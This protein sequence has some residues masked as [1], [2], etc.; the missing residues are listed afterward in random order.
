MTVQAE[1]P[2]Y[3]KTEHATYTTVVYA[4]AA[5]EEEVDISELT[6]IE[7]FAVKDTISV[8]S[9]FFDGNTE[10]PANSGDYPAAPSVDTGN[11]LLKFTLNDNP[12][13]ANT[14][15]FTVSSD[16]YE[17][18]LAV[19]VVFTT[20]RDKQIVTFDS[21]V[22]EDGKVE[23]GYGTHSFT[24]TASSNYAD[25]V[26]SYSSDNTAVASVDSAGNVA[27]HSAGE[28]KITAKAA[29]TGDD[30][31]GGY[32]A[33]SA[34]YVL[35]VHKKPVTVSGIKAEDKTYNGETG[36]VLD[37]SGALIDGVLEADRS[38]VSVEATGAFQD[39]NAGSGKTVNLSEMVLKGE[40]SGNYFIPEDGQQK[41][42]TAAISKAEYK[43]V[44]EVSRNTYMGASDSIDL[45]QMIAEG[46]T[47]VSSGI[48][49]ED[50]SVVLDGDPSVAD[51]KLNYKFADN[52][53]VGQQAIVTIPVTSTNYV[54]YNI[55]V[56]LFVTSL[57]R[58]TLTFA[59]VSEGTVETT[60]GESVTHTA[61]PGSGTPTI[62]YSS[63][64]TSIAT[65]DSSTGK[66]TTHKN[67]TVVISAFA[68][69]IPEH[70]SATESYS[71][72][73]KKKTAS[74]SWATDSLTY[75]GS[76][77]A[78]AASVSNKVGDDSITVT[79][80]GQETSVGEGYTATAV[81]LSDD[82]YELPELSDR[83][84]TF[85]I[86][87]KKVT[88][89]GTVTYAGKVYDGTVNAKAK[90]AE[91]SSWTFNNPPF[92]GVVEEDELTVA[93]AT[94]VFDNKN[95]GEN[96]TLI[97]TVTLG[98][99]SAANYQI[100]SFEIKSKIEKKTATV[101]GITA[102]N[103][104]YDGNT[105]AVMVVSGASLTG[106]LDDDNEKVNVSGATGSFADKNVAN[107]KA[108]TI[109][110]VTLGGDEA[111]NYSPDYSGI[112][113]LTANITEKKLSG[114]SWTMPDD[115]VYN[116]TDRGIPTAS[117]QGVLTGDEVELSV[118]IDGGPAVNRGSY[119]ARA[120][121]SAGTDKGNYSL[122][123]DPTTTMT[124]SPLTVTLEWRKNP[125][126][127]SPATGDIEYDYN[128]SPQAPTATVG[129]L[130]SGDG[131]N[132]TVSVEGE[133]TNVG[134][135]TA[136]AS[137]LGG[138][139][140]ANY[141]LPETLSD[142]QKAYSI[143]QSAPD[144]S[145]LPANQKP[146][147][148][149]PTYN[150]QPQAIIA[151]P[152]EL[153]SG[154]TNVQYMVERKERNS[155]EYRYLDDEWKDAIPFHTDS[156]YYKVHVKYIPDSNHTAFELPTPIETWINSKR[157]TD[158]VF[159]PAPGEDGKPHLKY[160]GEVICPTVSFNGICPGDEVTI[161]NSE[162]T[163]GD[164]INAGT[165]GVSVYGLSNIN[166][167]SP[168]TNTF[169]YVIDPADPPDPS[170]LD[171]KYKPAAT[172][173]EYNG[174]D[175]DLVTTPED[176]PT[177][178]TKVQYKLTGGEYG[179]SV[180]KGKNAGTYK[181]YAKY[182]ADSNHTDFELEIEAKIVPKT[183]ELSWSPEPGEDGRIKFIYDGSAQAPTATVSNLITGDVC[184]VTVTVSG[185]HLDA[186]AGDFTATASALSNSNYKLPDSPSKACYI[187]PAA[188]LE[189]ATL[190]SENKPAAVTGLKF[191]TDSV[192]QNLVTAPSSL[193]LGYTA[194]QYSLTNE[195]DW[196]DDIPKGTDAGDYNVYAYYVP[197]AN[198]TAFSLGPIPVTIGKAD[199][200]PGNV[201]KRRVYTLT[202]IEASSGY[203]AKDGMPSN[204]KPLSY[205]AD[206]ANISRSKEGGGSPSS[207]A[208][209][210]N[211][212]VDENG[213]VTATLSGEA[214][215]IIT[216]PVKVTSQNYEESTVNINVT[217]TE[218][219]AATV[220]FPETTPGSKVYGD[221]AFTLSVNVTDPGLPLPDSASPWSWESGDTSIAEVDSD[222]KVTIK[223]VGTVNLTAKYESLTAKGSQVHALTVTP[224]TVEIEWIGTSFPYDGSYHKPNAKVKNPAYSD[225]LTL[226]V[227]GDSQTEV[228]DNYPA[229]VTAINGEKNGCYVLPTEEAYKKTTFKI[230]PAVPE[231][232]KEPAAI[233]GLKYTGEAQTLIETGEVTNGKMSYF[234][235]ADDSTAAPS[236][237]DAG[238]SETAPKGTDAK[239]YK[240]YYQVKKTSDNYGDIAPKLISG[241]SI[242]KEDINSSVVQSGTLS[243]NG[244]EQAAEVTASPQTIHGQTVSYSYS[245]S[246]SGDYSSSVPKFKEARTYTVY[247][248]ASA[249][250]HNDESGSFDVTIDR[251][252]I[253]DADITLGDQLTYNGNEQVMTVS[254][255]K[256]GD[257]EVN[258]Y[259]V[260]GNKAKD[261]KTDGDYALTITG[262][263][264]F[265]DTATAN[266]NIGK[267]D[268]SANV[269]AIEKLHFTGG[270]L[271]LVTGSTGDGTLYY[272]LTDDDAVEPPAT[273]V[274]GVEKPKARDV[275]THYVWY[276]VKGDGNHNDSANVRLAC[277]IL[278]AAISYN[279][280]A[281]DG[282]YD[283]QDH[284]ISVTVTDPAGQSTVKYGEIEGV[285]DES[286][287]PLFRNADTYTVYFKITADGYSEKTD[288]ADV[289]IDKKT[290][291]INAVSKTK[292][293]GADDPGLTYEMEG[294][295]QGDENVITGKLVR[296]AGEDVGEYTIVQGTLKA[297]DNYS[298]DYKEAKFS[299]TPADS[300]GTVSAA[301]DLRYTGG[302][303]ELVKVTEAAK[304]G[305][306][307]YALTDQ[308][309]ADAPATGQTPSADWKA[310][311]PTAGAV[312]TYYVWYY[313][314]GDKN[315]Y[316]T[317]PQKLTCAIADS[318]IKYSVSAFDGQY[319]GAYHGIQ[320]TVT[321]P[322]GAVVKYG[323]GEGACDLDES[324]SYKDAGSHTVYFEITADNYGKVAN[325]ADVKIAKRPLTIAA[326]P[327]SKL[328]HTDDP[329]LTFRDNGQLVE[330]DS[331]T[332]ELARE[333]G[334]AV[335]TYPICQG[336]VTAGDN[337]EMSYIPAV[338]TITQA[339]PYDIMPVARVLSYNGFQQDLVEEDETGRL[340]Y[341]IDGENWSRDIPEGK[342]AGIY[343][344]LYM[345]KG[346]ADHKDSDPVD[347][348]VAILCKTLSVNALAQEK[349]YGDPDPELTYGYEGLVEGDGF[350]G[351][352]ERTEGDD[353]GTYAIT[354]GT[355][356]AGDN[357][358]INYTGQFLTIGR[359]GSSVT[360]KP[361]AKELI[362]NGSLQELVTEGE[363][364]GGTM[365]Y[366]IGEYTVAPPETGWSDR[367]PSAVADDMYIVWYRV[368]GDRNHFDSDASYVISR[369]ILTN[370]IVFVVDD[371][372]N[373]SKNYEAEYTG[374]SVR[375]EV[376]VFRDGIR[377][378][379]QRDYT[380]SYGNMNR[381]A[382][383]LS[384]GDAGFNGALA[385]SVTV[386]MKGY[387]S[388]KE[389]R[390]FTIRKARL[391]DAQ[392]SDV[393]LVAT[394]KPLRPRIV[395][396]YND[397]KLK[398]GKDYVLDLY[399]EDGSTRIDTLSE[400]G[401]YKAVA[402]PAGNNFMDKKEIGV[403]V[404]PNDAVPVSK[405]KVVFAKKQAWTGQ[406]IT[407]E[408]TVSYSGNTLVKDKD[409]T[410]SYGENICT[411]T[412]YV[413]VTGN[414]TDY[415]GSRTESF[416][417]TGVSLTRAKVFSKSG[418]EPFVPEVF[419][420]DGTEHSQDSEKYVV[421]YNGKALEEGTDYTVSYSGNLN[422]GKAKMIITAVRESGYTGSIK[423][424]F[425]ILP[426]PITGEDIVIERDMSAPLM[427]GGSVPVPGLSFNGMP[428]IEGT[429][430]TLTYKDNKKIG[431]TATYKVK[432]IGN[433]GGQTPPISFTITALP[434]DSEEIFVS[435]PDKVW[436]AGKKNYRQRITLM[437]ASGKALTLGE[438]K[439]YTVRYYLGDPEGDGREL[440]DED[441]AP[442][443]SE[444]FIVAAA[445]GS[446]RYT[447]SVTASYKLADAANVK[448][449]A[450]SSVR[451]ASKEHTG[452]PVELTGTDLTVI[453]KKSGRQLKPQDSDED[454]YR[455][456]SYYNNV[457]RGTAV[458]ILEGTGGV[459]GVRAVRFRIGKLSIRSILGIG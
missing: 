295:V 311:V 393:S 438:G 185:N 120:A 412:G 261:R 123:D 71:L 211:F 433:F 223:G 55:T 206:T 60:Y 116:G 255:V 308:E 299:I 227:S 379:E 86:V 327:A 117:P 307:Y 423:V 70:T 165:Q 271:E 45:S 359:A 239:S 93:E 79:V 386:K 171:A 46:G 76:P 101:S 69:A 436:R 452:Q 437:D 34:S 112:T 403:T 392:A 404:V 196:A 65:V 214:G 262:N 417:I 348:N 346:D 401:V 322:S 207:S 456:A 222:G 31:T 350:T 139:S 28:A 321:E 285:Y 6:S 215:D 422:A 302:Q 249:P 368:R 188:P 114:I 394:G 29:A 94:G 191:N 135:Y 210:S 80:T 345:V 77:Q 127:E 264:N 87:P 137:A 306:F 257:L 296:E 145:G 233:D 107:G 418:D 270:E 305:T 132:V 429:D 160:T 278:N 454:G 63:S 310:D 410:V 442:N 98:G 92:E 203:S 91:E 313:V 283:G 202:S 314:R 51:N 74:I 32:L 193:P 177:G 355:L 109:N 419:T 431:N 276:Y 97:V 59:D 15:S 380:V 22:V 267:A 38:Y 204:A 354:Q 8:T 396:T 391:S 451:A 182:Y 289:R 326:D 244:S 374:Q 100:D 187:L 72:T 111:G 89:K 18:F 331:I 119:T 195:G 231:I 447:G 318:D 371:E 49:V 176:C 292:E 83:Q 200:V 409:Y 54:N 312:G 62:T 179:D 247:Y 149:Q 325:N 263:G 221:D 124:V 277:K 134:N 138:T 164:G 432:G 168:Y 407:P 5:E 343:A 376:R 294:L 115:L 406:Q 67:G 237:D 445:S 68:A 286:V 254:G 383:T 224:R 151:A 118:S 329:A 303:Q 64:D 272:A 364:E 416:K 39:A 113:G 378:S 159:D 248:K 444:I 269:K 384:P 347:M 16:L 373:E 184:T 252:S 281:F 197:D 405:F 366:A 428:M 266:W 298:I 13:P 375:P 349:V 398:E 58:Q 320:V 24:C 103:K 330:G 301:E 186:N 342:D 128:G 361:V 9:G 265:K 372:G 236:P 47:I 11:G 415:F 141:M 441:E 173:P 287:S 397:R 161:T 78:P 37:Y 245:A 240:V 259:D 370:R 102:D 434:L 156:A 430:Y 243:Y 126:D 225:V 333:E 335:G 122:P 53:P 367:I 166:Y 280:T 147:A 353:A 14:L 154:Y 400:P 360:K 61:T 217:L 105:S 99:G 52:A 2:G 241:V 198:H 420:Y 411:G 334:E 304:G 30:Y 142:R 10:Y 297:G 3:V 7:G 388:G 66:V 110:G 453:L 435:A 169:Y 4:K 426:H 190:P 340:Y 382:Y 155:S 157:L 316:D 251:R 41:T 457:R 414:G 332:G 336:T 300:S 129:N 175:Q 439:D 219:T 273:L 33:G 209:A 446:G 274:W 131:C 440:G 48:S 443:G 323:R 324:P 27:I 275:G 363:A 358:I 421:R 130:V 413:T 362:Y 81:E 338:F 317:V 288:S 180:P 104:T 85:K 50:P 189:P 238:W 448:S 12:G 174:Q 108:V 150:K 352:L 73:V 256:C 458:V 143:V 96:K 148:F 167:T 268:S 356:S 208:G 172:N 226:T 21:D 385:P 44:K 449:L 427:L 450:Q 205:T 20:K 425:R 351:A 106:V 125:T 234:L 43:G 339:G 424:P 201:G 344:F 309:S 337:Y 133:H 95:A 17:D 82:R 459:T 230:T 250:N 279:V 319:D 199:A 162:I 57:K 170:T 220:S 75:N 218:K 136:T 121:I 291:S 212:A 42:A 258:D 1:G 402:T 153:P 25:A 455:I 158:F 178:Y 140:S 253:A 26:I 408:V 246:K 216:L 290:L 389:T 357:Y 194:V 23:R 88:V 163:Y 90:T 328:F 35:T 181:V 84:K 293:F 40:R 390:Y 282:T 369:M 146:A 36:A 232:I 56:E 152:E 235:A 341:S 192:S 260:T 365:E 242:G 144:P 377:L 229:E 19:F 399:S 228:G 315:H 183:A 395:L 284:G 387:Y 213:I 381:D